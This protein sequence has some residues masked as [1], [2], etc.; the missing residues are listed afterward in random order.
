VQEEG[1]K[2]EVNNIEWRKGEKRRGEIGGVRRGPKG[3]T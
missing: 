2:R 3:D 1:L